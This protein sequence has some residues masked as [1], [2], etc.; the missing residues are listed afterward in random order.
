MGTRLRDIRQKILS[1]IPYEMLLSRPEFVL[2]H[3][4]FGTFVLTTE[5][6]LDPGEKIK[7]H[8]LNDRDF[9]GDFVLP[10]HGKIYILDV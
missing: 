1:C 8:I 6:I 9:I 2:Y 3:L 10:E 5:P 7:K 4:H